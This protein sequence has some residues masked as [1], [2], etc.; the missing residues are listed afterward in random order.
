TNGST[1]T[2]EIAADAPADGVRFPRAATSTHAIARTP[3][4][5]AEIAR[6][7]IGFRAVTAAE[8]AALSG[9]AAGRAAVPVLVG[10]PKAVANSFAVG[11]RSAGFFASPRMIAASI[12]GE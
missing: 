5:A 1:A 11:N 8:G 9:S 4:T 12:S 6:I 2:E 7:L 3:A 10:P